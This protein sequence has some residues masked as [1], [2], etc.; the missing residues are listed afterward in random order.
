LSFKNVQRVLEKLLA[1]YQEIDI[2]RQV[3]PL[4]KASQIGMLENSLVINFFFKFERLL[5][6]ANVAQLIILES[7]QFKLLLEALL[8]S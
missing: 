4:K 3:T 8:P 2:D 5:D 6:E 7:Q 1:T